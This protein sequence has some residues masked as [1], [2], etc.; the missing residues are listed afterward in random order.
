M[1]KVLFPVVLSGLAV[2][3]FGCAA[4][5]DEAG[6]DE[7]ALGG[8]AAPSGTDGEVVAAV[9]TSSGTRARFI[10]GEGNELGVELVYRTGVADPALDAARARQRTGGL[11]GYYE[12][13]AG[14]TAPATL[15]EAVRVAS[16]AAREET[17]SVDSEVESDFPLVAPSAPSAV[18][19]PGN[20]CD[21][22]PWADNGSG[23]FDHCWPNMNGTTKLQMKVDHLGC[24]VDAIQG[25]ISIRY[26]YKTGVF[27]H[28][29]TSI[30]N[31][32]AGWTFEWD[33]AYRYAKR[34]RE[35]HV[36]ANA[37]N[38]LHH[39]RAGGHEKLAALP[40]N[41]SGVHYP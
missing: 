31:M 25:P 5:V 2:S 8:L 33:G 9:E 14:R 19:I 10:L 28:T 24:R 37:G 16:L 23:A 18:A 13:L 34:K 6:V 22:V 26:K 7:S 11:I 36:F 40:A 4:P 39:F 30:N 38:K 20:F 29:P 35:C 1:L 3:A 27:W 21:I 15:R 12:A 32:P 17:T 41:A